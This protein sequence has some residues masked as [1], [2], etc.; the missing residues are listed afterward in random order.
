MTLK[1]R[2]ESEKGVTVKY[3]DSLVTMAKGEFQTKLRKY[4]NL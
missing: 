3:V 2:K 4:K 1:Q